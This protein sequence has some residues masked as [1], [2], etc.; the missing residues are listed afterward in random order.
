MP[1]VVSDS[2][3]FL[4]NRLLS[5]YLN[6]SL[7]LLIAGAHIEDI[8]RAA[9]RFGMPLGPLALYDLVGIDTSFYAGRTLWEAFPDRIAVLPVL[10]ALFRSGRL[11]QK[12][13]VGFYRYDPGAKRGRPDPQ[14]DQLLEPYVRRTREISMQEISDR[15][16]LPVLLEATRVLEAGIIRD[17]RDV[18]LGMIYA[19]GFP[20]DRGGLL[21]WADQL[22][23]ER[24]VQMLKPYESLG[25]RFHPTELLLDMARRRSK[26]YDSVPAE[27]RIPQGKAL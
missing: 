27:A 9:E 22:G 5:P 17:V 14:V 18:D 19:L 10:P 7:E 15:L 24:I 1:I 2:P 4:V 21:F 26:F 3:G 23:A 12:A 16:F 11:G 25:S 6:E 13:G 20:S 8:D